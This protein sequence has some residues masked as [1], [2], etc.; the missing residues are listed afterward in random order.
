MSKSE[1]RFLVKIL[2]FCLNLKV[3]PPYRC[4]KWFKS[5]HLI[6]QDVPDLHRFLSFH[7]FYPTPG[8]FLWKK[9]GKNSWEGSADSQSQQAGSVAK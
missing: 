9:S 4:P 6:C 1:E 8:W 5:T 3:C 7:F 2:S